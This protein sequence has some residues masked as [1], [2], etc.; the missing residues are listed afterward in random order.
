VYRF[1]GGYLSLCLCYSALLLLSIIRI[2]LGD[3]LEICSNKDD[4]LYLLDQFDKIFNNES[5]HIFHIFNRIFK[6]FIKFIQYSYILLYKI[7]KYNN[8]IIIIKSIIFQIISLQPNKLPHKS[9]ILPSYF[10]YL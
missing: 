9:L 2:Y 1:V 4:I 3:Q 5:Y 10:P 7:T 8:N 6:N